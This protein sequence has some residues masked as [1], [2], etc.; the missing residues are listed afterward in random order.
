MQQY[1]HG[2]TVLFEISNKPVELVLKVIN[3]LLQIIILLFLTL[4]IWVVEDSV[5]AWNDE[6]DAIVF[7]NEFLR[8]ILFAFLGVV[9]ILGRH[10]RN[11]K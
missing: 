1:Q 9:Q 2:R 5:K 4:E 8:E 10:V 3:L 11:R 7:V 6:I